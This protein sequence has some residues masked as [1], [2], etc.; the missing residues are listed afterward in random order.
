MLESYVRSAPK[1]HELYQGNLEVRD[2]ACREYGRECA[3][4][5]VREA[6]GPNGHAVAPES[7]IRA[8]TTEGRTKELPLRATLP[9]P[10]KRV[11][12]R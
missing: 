2:Y 11:L 6:L 4:W 3:D 10:V 8:Q 5:L 1:R 7:S 9:N 12:S